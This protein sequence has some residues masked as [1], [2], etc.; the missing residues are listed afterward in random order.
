MSDNKRF[1][2]LLKWLIKN[3]SV[4]P[5]LKLHGGDERGIISKKN[6]TDDIPVKIHESCFITMDNVR[7]TSYGKTLIGNNEHGFQ[8]KA[9]TFITIFMLVDMN[10]PN[11]FYKD[12][13]DILPTNIDNFPILWNVEILKII[14]GSDIVGKIYER[15]NILLMIIKSYVAIVQNLKTNFHL[16]N[17]LKLDYWLEV[18]ILVFL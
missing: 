17:L 8:N 7:E 14:E 3:D 11:S 18:E 13:Y 1:D 4:V 2:N 15:K 16:N 6:I 10:N 5:E 9:L 12:Y